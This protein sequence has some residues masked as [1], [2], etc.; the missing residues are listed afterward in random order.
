MHSSTK[1]S[2]KL[3]A[4]KAERFLWDLANLGPFAE[5]EVTGRFLSR[6]LEWLPSAFQQGNETE[7]QRHYDHYPEHE[8]DGTVVKYTPY[9]VNKLAHIR[10]MSAWLEKIW[11]VPEIHAREWYILEFRADI[12]RQYG[13]ADSKANE[14]EA[15]LPWEPYR[16]QAVATPGLI[17]QALV[18]LVKSAH[19]LRRCKNPDCKR[20]FFFAVRRGQKHCSERCAA[21]AQ[22][23]SKRK[24]WAKHGEDWRQKKSHPKRGKR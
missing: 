14:P 6:Y 12:R 21:P 5:D 1:L 9:T 4:R 13:W 23:E 16:W 20:P 17:D 2:T 22:R 8:H 11:T 10:W 15:L 18:Y 19:R 3:S 7:W 24:W